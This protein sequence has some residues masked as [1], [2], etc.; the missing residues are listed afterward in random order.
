MRKG[1]ATIPLLLLL[2][3]LSATPLFGQGS[4]I[5]IDR[6][7]VLTTGSSYPVVKTDTLLDLVYCAGAF[8]D[9]LQVDGQ[10]TESHGELDGY[11]ACLDDRLHLRWLVT[12]KGVGNESIRALSVI[13]GGGVLFAGFAGANT[14]TFTSYEIGG[15]TLGG[16]GEADAVVGRISINGT[17]EWV[18]NDGLTSYEI[19]TDIATLPN[20]TV[21]VVGYFD[22]MSR[23]GDSI[24]SCGEESPGGYIQLLSGSGEHQWVTHSVSDTSPLGEQGNARFLQITNVTDSSFSVSAGGEYASRIQDVDLYFEEQS[25]T[26]LRC[27]F[28]GTVS[29]H[30]SWQ[31]CDGP[32]ALTAGAREFEG[33]STNDSPWCGFSQK[34][35]VAFWH[36]D[37]RAPK[38][39]IIEVFWPD[40]SRPGIGYVWAFRRGPRSTILHAFTDTLDLLQTPGPPDLIIDS[41]VRRQPYLIYSPTPGVFTTAYKLPV[42]GIFLAQGI[43]PVANGAICSL[44]GTGTI[45]TTAGT[46][47]V[48]DGK[49][50]L[51]RVTD[52]TVSVKE[53][54]PN[55]RHLEE[56]SDERPHA[57]P[58]SG[59]GPLFV[60]DV[61]GTLLSTLS[62]PGTLSSTLSSALPPGVYILRQGTR[63]SLCHVYGPD[64]IAFALPAGSPR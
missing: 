58:L 54:D 51:V 12:L 48:P 21:A 9:V 49:D 17:L 62:H 55:Q 43:A 61:A 39:T 44:S 1:L 14:T 23:F 36:R 35:N 50:V 30:A 27:S 16:K 46:V 6:A 7:V 56:R 40:G 33:F 25:T 53:A 22:A 18:R 11:I 19:P 60:Y 15:V 59:E 20:G 24:V 28:D 26:H 31:H 38:D 63:V 42:Q 3:L 2:P 32:W 34:R 45:A 57:F 29:R 10:E 47:D 37:Y 52:P 64:H 13:P 5:D 41:G 8:K 4:T